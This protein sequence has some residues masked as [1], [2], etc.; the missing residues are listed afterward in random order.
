MWFYV[1]TKEATAAK[2]L[3]SCS[4]SGS[5]SGGGGGGGSSGD[6][7][8]D[9]AAAALYRICSCVHI[10]VLMFCVSPVDILISTVVLEI[11]EVQ[12]YTH[13]VL[14]EVTT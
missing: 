12:L 4:G 6:G 1:V 5:A 8:G 11:R 14:G 3:C 10:N 2:I 7:G 13:S 9:D